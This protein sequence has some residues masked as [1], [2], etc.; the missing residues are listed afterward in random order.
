ML[1]R[2][3]CA[4]RRIVHSRLDPS[5]SLGSQHKAQLA[6]VLGEVLA[7][8]TVILSTMD[9]EL[10]QLLNERITKEGQTY[11]FSNWT[12]ED[13]PTIVPA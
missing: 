10:R 8:K 3:G 11:L 4:A 6:E 2:A 1:T 5:Q 13:G 9:V 7:T 12:Q